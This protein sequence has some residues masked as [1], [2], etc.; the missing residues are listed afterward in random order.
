MEETVKQEPESIEMNDEEIKQ[1]LKENTNNQPKQTLQ[2]RQNRRYRKRL[3]Q[4]DMLLHHQAHRTLPISRIPN[5]QW[6]LCLE[7]Q[8]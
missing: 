1:F 4:R 8:R 6:K 5:L 2:K 7:K 3:R